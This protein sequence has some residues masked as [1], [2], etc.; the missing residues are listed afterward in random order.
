MVKCV[1][2]GEETFEGRQCWSFRGF[3]NA[4]LKDGFKES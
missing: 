2:M 4:D 1:K 3:K